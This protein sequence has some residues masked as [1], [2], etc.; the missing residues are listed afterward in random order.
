[1]VSTCVFDSL[2]PEY[3]FCNRFAMVSF[4]LS[5]CLPA[6]FLAWQTILGPRKKDR[7]GGGGGGGRKSGSSGG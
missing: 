7:R 4:C 5:A 3:W 1:M 6:N 2:C